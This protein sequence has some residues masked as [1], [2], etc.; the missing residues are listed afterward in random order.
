MTTLATTVKLKKYPQHSP[1]DTA[2]NTEGNYT[3]ITTTPAAITTITTTA[4]I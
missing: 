3:T 2:T 4:S 1:I